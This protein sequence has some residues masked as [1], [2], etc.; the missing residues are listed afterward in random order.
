MWF[1]I[2]YV[3]HNMSV[4]KYF[5]FKYLSNAIR[6]SVRLGNLSVFIWNI[7]HWTFC[8]NAVSN[9]LINFVNSQYSWKWVFSI[10]RKLYVIGKNWY[11]FWILCDKLAKKHVPIAQKHLGRK[12]MSTCVIHRGREEGYSY[13][14][15]MFPCQCIPYLFLEMPW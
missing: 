11:H 7:K 8:W 12:K 15:W 10:Q 2:S 14:Q 4:S 9:F 5:R 1:H 6:V 3:N 13:N